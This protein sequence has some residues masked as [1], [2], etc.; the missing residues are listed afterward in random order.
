MNKGR[1]AQCHDNVTTRTHLGRAGK[2]HAWNRCPD[3]VRAPPKGA[4]RQGRQCG[5]CPAALRSAPAAS[6]EARAA[7]GHPAV[8]P[9]RLLLR[10]PPPRASAPG[11][12]AGPRAPSP[13]A[14]EERTWKPRGQALCPCSGCSVERPGQGQRS[15]RSPGGGE[16]TGGRAREPS[17]VDTAAG[18]ALGQ[19]LQWQERLGQRNFTA[20]LRPCASLG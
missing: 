5:P 7:R 11:W 13:R 1:R 12:G 19:M 14:E 2:T 9:G 18:Q 10:P 16:D 15:V 8:R 3:A 17:G 4:A 20:H 6:T